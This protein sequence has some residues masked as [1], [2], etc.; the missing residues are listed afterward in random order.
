MYRY[1]SYS[2]MKVVLV[3]DEQTFDMTTR[4]RQSLNSLV[5]AAEV[6]L[7]DLVLTTEQIQHVFDFAVDI[8]G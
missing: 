6:H 5:E 3:H 8:E 7:K 1:L 4:V 2:N